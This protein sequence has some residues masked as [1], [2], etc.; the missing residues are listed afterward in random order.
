[1]EIRVIPCGTKI[2]DC[3][4]NLKSLNRSLLS[5]NSNEKIKVLI[6][7]LSLFDD[8]KYN[9]EAVEFKFMNDNKNIKRNNSV[10]VMLNVAIDT[11]SLYLVC[12][13]CSL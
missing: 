12:S 3:Q 8:Y 6:V 2:I 10:T 13:F 7:S 1:M 5:I 4:Y 11:F 9:Y